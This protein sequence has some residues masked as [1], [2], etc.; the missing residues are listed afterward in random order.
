MDVPATGETARGH[1]GRIAELLLVRRRW[2]APVA[3]FLA[4]AGAAGLAL[5][6]GFAS[7][8]PERNGPLVAAT[9]V[10]AVVL[11][12]GAAALPLL[13]QRLQQAN[14][15]E[16]EAAA[17][18]IAERFRLLI[19]AGMQPL[20]Q[21]LWALATAPTPEQRIEQRRAA[22]IRVMETVVRTF[23]DFTTT[24]CVVY[25]LNDDGT[26][27]D[28]FDQSGRPSTVPPKPFLRDEARG[29]AVFAMLAGPG[30][31]PSQ[32]VVDC[33]R[34][35]PAGWDPRTSSYRCFLSVPIRTLVRTTGRTSEVTTY[36][37]L[38]ADTA[39]PGGIAA[40]D[41]DILKMMA[42]LVALAFVLAER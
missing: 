4:A 5:A 39:A 36:G 18:A 26:R 3:A 30:G 42:D 35:R 34:E 16:L 6:A 29:G 31:P 2:V 25:L 17:L 32:Y 11:A 15:A 13:V 40:G 37:L 38:T 33:A 24:R 12:G 9:V 14:R 10:G 8:G 21:A 23:G 22:V 28:C 41:V 20:V 27:L 7:M 19:V 1:V